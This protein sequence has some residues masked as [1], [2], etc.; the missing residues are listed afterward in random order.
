MYE[1]NY[2]WS[3]FSSFNIFLC[4]CWITQ[5]YKL[6]SCCRTPFKSCQHHFDIYIFVFIHILTSFTHICERQFFHR[7]TLNM[8][9]IQI[10]SRL[11][12]LEKLSL[13][14]IVSAKSTND[15]ARNHKKSKCLLF[16]HRW[17]K[18]LLWWY[19][20]LSSWNDEIN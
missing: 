14:P 20:A 1:F 17:N 10:F 16:L 6:E 4:E 8:I 5:I 18:F 15:A 12:A 13:N 7:T 19:S 3:C 9:G 11:S 2:V